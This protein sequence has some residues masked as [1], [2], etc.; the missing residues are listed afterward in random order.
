MSVFFGNLMRLARLGVPRTL[1]PPARSSRHIL[2]LRTFDSSRSYRT[3]LMKSVLMRRVCACSSAISR[4]SALDFLPSWVR[5]NNSYN[6]WHRSIAALPG[7]IK[8]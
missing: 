6:T 5:I 7:R 1:A 4:F 3:I 8:S 2:M